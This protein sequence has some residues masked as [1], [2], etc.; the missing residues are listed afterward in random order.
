VLSNLAC[1]A[2]G[3]SERKQIN[4]QAHE[5]T[6]VALHLVVSRVS[7][8]LEEWFCRKSLQIVLPKNKR[9]ITWVVR[10]F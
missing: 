5:N 10:F 8:F 6:V 7:Y 9:R 2:V 1:V 4:P 3:A